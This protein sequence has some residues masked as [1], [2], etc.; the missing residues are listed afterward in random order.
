[1]QREPDKVTLRSY[2]VGFGDC[3]LLSFHYDDQTERNVLID[4]GS[5][6]TPQGKPGVLID[7]ARS[8]RER[9]NGQLTA[10]VAT[11]RHKDHI[12]GFRTSDTGEAPG[13]IIRE[14]HP[15]LVMQPWTEQP[16]LDT[17]ATAP[18]D[19]KS[20]AAA[21]Q[22]LHAISE[23]IAKEAHFYAEMGMA[24]QLAFLGENNLPNPSAIKNLMSMGESAEYVHFGYASA[25]TTLLPGVNVSV[26]GPPTLE[27]SAAIKHQRSHDEE[28][29]W[30]L[31]QQRVRAAKPG[32]SNGGPNPTIT[33]SRLA[34]VFAC[35]PRYSPAENPPQARW[36][37]RKMQEMRGRELLDLVRTL[38][39]VLNNTSVI[40][41][42]EF[43]GK[44]L[45]FPG[46]AQ[47]ENWAYALDQDDICEKLKDVNLYKVGHHGSLNAT[48][49]SLLDL[50]KNKRS[51]DGQ[52]TA[53]MKTVVSTLAGKHG[54]PE[55]G[56]E[57]P[58]VRLV[59]ELK[60]KT[61][62]YTTQFMEGS[63]DFY[64]DIEIL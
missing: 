39:K 55:D 25:L 31:W 15:R 4:F 51:G 41:L 26:L 46:D 54:H 29:F 10:V 36:F 24:D 49:K 42:F 58:R 33:E 22:D 6:Q 21:L 5:T 9:T 8:I 61:E 47:I 7:T 2:H 64:H 13:N 34:P 27:Q 35:A 38:D 16:D 44:K 17:S 40:L 56:T 59:S 32:F 30:H 12:D 48:P 28:E 37:R 52:T 20:F 11:H 1:M 18:P 57:V 23:A 43:C 14:C 45:L 62:Y 50:F 3:F 19:R 53:P 63:M 60:E